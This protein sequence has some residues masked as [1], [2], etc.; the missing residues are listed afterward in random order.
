[1]PLLFGN[2]TNSIHLESGC[3]WIWTQVWWVPKPVWQLPCW[4]L[5][6]RIP[7]A[8]LLIFHVAL[9]LL[10]CGDT[11]EVWIGFLQHT[12]CH[13]G[14][15]GKVESFVLNESAA[16]TEAWTLAL[17]YVPSQGW[18]WASR[19]LSNSLGK[20]WT[21]QAPYHLNTTGDTWHP[22]RN[23]SSPGPLLTAGWHSAHP[24]QHWNRTGHK[25]SPLCFY[26]GLEIL[27][28]KVFCKYQAGS[29]R[30]VQ[31]IGKLRQFSSWLK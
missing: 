15:K 17:Y 6:Q 23:L 9:H 22:L 25:I 7:L 26:H 2:L 12:F 10:Q 18:I 28:A 16:R 3:V 21:Q 13:R 29:N 27:M 1:M 31:K 19:C 8:V 5:Q 24:L 11:L 20:H 4:W 30:G 14:L